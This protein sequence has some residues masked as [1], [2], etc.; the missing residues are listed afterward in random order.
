MFL[1][2]TRGTVDIIIAIFFLL[3][4][5]L[6]GAIPFGIII[7]KLFK[8]ID[9]REH[10]SKNIG[11]TNAI[12]VLGK[13]VGFL[14][15]FLDVFKGMIMIIIARILHENDIFFKEAI[16]TNNINVDYLMIG[17]SAIIGHSFSIFIGFKGGKAVAT[18]L[19]VISIICPIASLL[20]LITFAITL[21]ATGF[22]SLASTFAAITVTATMWVFYGVGVKE[23]S[24][25]TYFI[26]KQSL[27]ACLIVTTMAV[28]IILKHRKNYIR[29][30]NGTEN[31]F[32]KAKRERKMKE[33][34]N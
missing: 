18:S 30:L 6:I 17:V 12:R 29:L 23:T 8:G 32:K 13:R 7:G 25:A 34:Q 9:I 15:F 19:G 3:I 16:I 31:N 1:M 28:L 4:S 11:S 33:N 2:T 21:F 20:C 24:F 5:Y 27:P 10:G 14:V 22:V 26:S